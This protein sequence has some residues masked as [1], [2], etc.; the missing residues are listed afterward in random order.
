MKQI[1][2]FSFPDGIRAKRLGRNSADLSEMFYG[3]QYL[4][5]ASS[6]FIF[7]LTGNE[8][9]PLYG[10]CVVKDEPVEVRACMNQFPDF[11]TSTC[12]RS[13][14]S[15]WERLEQLKWESWQINT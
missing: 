6:S 11:H 5:S 8:S 12:S 14:L 15:S 1:A 4:H 9:K 7:L 13:Y 10:M 3:Q 2:G